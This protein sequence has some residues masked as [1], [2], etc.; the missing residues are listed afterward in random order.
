MPTLF[1]GTVFVN[2]NVQFFDN[3]G[4]P[5]AGGF[6]QSYLAGT[7]TPA[8]TYSDSD[9]DPIL[10][11]NVNPIELDSSGRS[12]VPIFLAPIGY[13]FILSDADS[14]QIWS[15]DD[16][17]G[18]NVFPN[19]FGTLLTEGG[20]NVTTGYTVLDTDRLVTVDS[21]G[22]ATVV[23]LLA[24]GDATQL[25]TIKNL[26]TNTVTVTPDGTDTIDGLTSYVIAAAASPLFPTIMLAS[27]GVSSWWILASHS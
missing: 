18:W 8:E 26:G 2:P 14:V 23:N 11:A 5:L 12:P 25:L 21:S 1:P 22:G 13:K 15:R 19:L 17:E 27:D 3:D 7:T 20:S 16:V 24:A 4:N 6:L 10:H 9:L